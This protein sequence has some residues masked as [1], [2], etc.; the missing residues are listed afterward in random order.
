MGSFSK[1]WDKLNSLE[2]TDFEKA[3]IIMRHIW[4]KQNEFVFNE[5]L[6]SLKHINLL[7]LQ[8]HE[9]FQSS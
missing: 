2:Q 6:A 3:A 5:K 4:F 1:F 9:V 8:V 7:A